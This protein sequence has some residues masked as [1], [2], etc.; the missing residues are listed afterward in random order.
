MTDKESFEKILEPGYIGKLQTKNRI[1]KVCGGA[2]D[3]TEKNLAFHE[4]LARGGAGLIIYGD[5]TPDVPLGRTIP[6]TKRHMENDSY[7]PV[8]SKI[9]DVIH[10]NGGLVFMQLF[11]A[12]PQAWLPPELQTVSSSV[13]TESE[14]K[15]LTIS[16]VPRQLTVADI[17][18]LVDKF[19]S[20]AERAKKAGYDGVEVN[21][22]R[23]HL[24]NSFFSRA[25]NKRHDEYGCDSL[26][27]RA[28]FMVE[29]VQ[30]IKRRLGPDFPISTLIN[31]LE[32]D[33]PNGITIDEAQGFGRILQ[34]AGS[35][36]IHVRAFGYHGFGN[37][38]QCEKPYYAP[39]TA[40][41]L[42]KELDWTHKG[43]G[44][45]VPLAAAVKQV[46]SIPVIAVSRLDPVLGEKILREGKADF[47]AMCRRLMADPEMP[48]KL[49]SGRA[50]DIAPCTACDDCSKN[51]MM[52]T[53]IRCR[54]NAALGGDQEYLIRP[55]EKRK[56]V[57]VVGGGPGGMEAARVAA[58]RGHNVIL[59][60]KEPELGGLLP[61]V[62]VVKGDDVDRDANTLAKYLKDQITKLGVKIQLGKEFSP[63]LIGEVKPDVIILAPGG[64][65][66]VPEIPGI[67][68]SNVLGV[69]ELHSRLKDY[70]GGE[71]ATQKVSHKVL[72]AFL[73]KKIVIIGGTTEGFTLAG[74]LV[75]HGRDVTIVDTGKVLDMNRPIPDEFMFM[76]MG[77]RSA[78]KPAVIK[79]ARYEE[80]TGKGLTITTRDGKRQTIEVDTI[81]HALTPRP[82]TELLKEF[83]GKAPE[84]YLVSGNDD[85][86]LDSIMDAV[87]NGYRVARAV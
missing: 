39:E 30:E 22:A 24:I 13:L 27:N 21:G 60:E 54:V 17:H 55:A 44:A 69:D 75:E 14:A 9:A 1:I 28:R 65:P 83:E 82:N 74:F 67:D 56:K 61:W 42:P 37:V 53:P 4:A 51:L 3:I 20:L 81:I 18:D 38:D 72:D 63:S 85:K 19:A 10:K 73:G 33:I 15:E 49:A 58:I 77:Y 76:L 35:D 2:E 26:E 7:I 59:Y 34:K 70:E 62:A 8:F 11:H 79:E 52:G 78:K 46:V 32:V 87:G 84:V 80:I 71:G 25:W 86:G 5:V 50:Q 64:V 66:V 57:V 16:R 23:M 40:H 48:N 36:A 45:L 68:G 43:E 31:G 6:N 29:I 41:R 12:G 47:I